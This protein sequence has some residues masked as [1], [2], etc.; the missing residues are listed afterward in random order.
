MEKQQREV[1]CID[2][3]GRKHVCYQDL[4]NKPLR[5]CARHTGDTRSSARWPWHANVDRKMCVSTLVSLARATFIQTSIDGQSNQR[6]EALTCIANGH[7]LPHTWAIIATAKCMWQ[8]ILGKV[9]A[10]NLWRTM[11]N[12]ADC[13]QFNGHVHQWLFISIFFFIYFLFQYT[14]TTTT[15]ATSASQ[16][17]GVIGLTAY[18]QSFVSFSRANHTLSIYGK[19]RESQVEQKAM[20]CKQWKTAR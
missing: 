13:Y 11:A 16:Q 4:A 2:P 5:F 8:P 7:R 10:V 3:G 1:L 15:T 9:H 12:D 17:P 6:A 18:F 19:R 14:T 20:K